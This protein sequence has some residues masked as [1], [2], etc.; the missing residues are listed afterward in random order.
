MKPLNLKSKIF[1]DG[2]DPEESSQLIKLLGFLDGQTTNPSLVSKNPKVAKKLSKGERFNK[3]ELLT[4]YKD[5][6]QKISNVIPKGSVSVEVYADEKTSSIEML[7]QAKKM[8]SWI[9]N[10][11]IKFPTNFEGLKAAEEA[12]ELGMK[13]NMTLVFSQEQAAAVYSATKGAKKGDVFISPFVGRL[14]DR[15][16]NGMDLIKN[17]LKMLESGDG[18]VDTLTASV[19]NL[20][21]LLY[22]ISLGSDII[23][24]PFKILKEWGE[25]ELIMPDKD[26]KYEPSLSEI[27]LKVLD[28][29]Q[30]WQEF[31][32]KHELTDIG[33][34]R[35]SDDWNNLIKS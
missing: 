20:D 27:P 34:K 22:A 31:D 8:Y 15:G 28:L 14:D 35:F 3:D 24:S 10:A 9:P 21:H 4:F 32:I 19:R 6:V 17:I 5:I 18:H 30:N 11:H 12:V 26:F 2:G 25:K 29:N 13:I 1:L 23:T 33:I 16:E 7:N